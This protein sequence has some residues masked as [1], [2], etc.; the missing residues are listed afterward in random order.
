MEKNIFNWIFLLIKNWNKFQALW[1][2]AFVGLWGESLLSSLDLSISLMIAEFFYP[3][4]SSVKR[5]KCGWAVR[6]LIWVFELEL[7]VHG[8][9]KN[10]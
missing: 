8:S 4:A 9:F 6:F 10:M 5:V 1:A 7:Q 3:L 2:R